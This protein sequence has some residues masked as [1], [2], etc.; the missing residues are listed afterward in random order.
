M[1]T[2][3][4]FILLIALPL[5]AG[6]QKS[7]KP[8]LKD[9]Y[10]EMSPKLLVSKYEATNNDYKEFLN[11]IRKTVSADEWQSLKP[12]STLWIKS[13][14]Y[15]FN[16]PW[17]EMYNNH[18]AFGNYPVVN[19]TQQT[20]AKYCAWKTEKYNASPDRTYKKVVFRLPTA[21]EWMSFSSAF[22]GKRLP[23]S[24][25]DPYVVTSKDQIV[26]L[27]NLKVK[28]YATGHYKYSFDDALTVSLVGKF[29]SNK[30]GLFDIIGNVAEQTSDNQVKGGSWDNTLEES[31]IDLSQSFIAPDPRVGFRVVMEIV[32]K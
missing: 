14:K 24:G 19:I 32:E 2:A 21:T 16:E 15:S 3:F 8:S 5:V 29:K 27:A 23:W 31:Y 18:A 22:I 13:F 10:I 11:D 26:P 1:K 30:L 25:N 4:I 17:V 9:A 12:D 6:A 28:D 7:K 20:M